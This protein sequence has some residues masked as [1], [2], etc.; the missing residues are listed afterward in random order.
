MG[1]TIRPQVGAL[2]VRFDENGTLE[3]LLITSRRSRKWIIPKGNPMK[4]LAPHHAAA[5]EAFEE[6]GAIGAIEGR[7]RG[8][9]RHRTRKARRQFHCRVAVYVMAVEKRLERFPEQDERA[10]RWF[11]VDDARSVIRNR[12]LREL[13]ARVSAELASSGRLPGELPV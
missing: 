5:R 2:P 3:V 10:V 7:S 11:T 1:V 4:R 12:R 8:H 13:I 6:A 9:Y